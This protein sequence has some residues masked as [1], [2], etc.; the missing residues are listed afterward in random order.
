MTIIV[1]KTPLDY[2]KLNEMVSKANGS[3]YADKIT[4]VIE[5]EMITN[6]KFSASKTIDVDCNTNGKNILAVVLE[7]NKN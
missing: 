4:S 7:I 2:N 3:S 6:V 1:S 5:S